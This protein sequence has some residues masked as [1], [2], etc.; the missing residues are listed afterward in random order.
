M[1]SVLRKSPTNCTYLGVR[2]EARYA[3]N[4][5]RRQATLAGAVE[6]LFASINPAVLKGEKLTQVLSRAFT[7]VAAL[8]EPSGAVWRSTYTS[9]K[10][11]FERLAKA[12]EPDSIGADAHLHALLF[13]PDPGT[14]S[15]RLS[16]ADAIVQL[17]KLSPTRAEAIRADVRA[18]QRDEKSIAV[19]DR[20]A[21]AGAAPLPR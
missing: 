20:L 14:E 6:S 19:R 13:G 8:P 2:G 15:L 4:R 10:R 9:L 17:A 12:R 5:F 16:R 21:K 11:L 3:D 7:T 1:E 18:L